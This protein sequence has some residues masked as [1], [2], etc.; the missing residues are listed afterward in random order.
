MSIMNPLQH[1]T[2]LLEEVKRSNTIQSYLGEKGQHYYLDVEH[3]VVSSASIYGS[4]LLFNE[5]GRLDF[6][7]KQELQ[8]AGYPVVLLQSSSAGWLIA[9]IHVIGQGLV[10]CYNEALLKEEN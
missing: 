10:V 3:P 9:G 5:K 6:A 4:E 7:A 1:L 2:L 8:R